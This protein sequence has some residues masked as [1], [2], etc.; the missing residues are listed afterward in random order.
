MVLNTQGGISRIISAA[1]AQSNIK[2]RKW[3]TREIGDA[4]ATRNGSERI[5]QEVVPASKGN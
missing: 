4:T 5:P 3:S 2:R 1:C